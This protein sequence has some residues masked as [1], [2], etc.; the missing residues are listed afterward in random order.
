MLLGTVYLDSQEIKFEFL[1]GEKSMGLDKDSEDYWT[2][3]KPI[4]KG[5]HYNEKYYF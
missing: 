1:W 2:F 4:W 3:P 5:D